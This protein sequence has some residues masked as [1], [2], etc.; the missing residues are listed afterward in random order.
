[1]K[2]PSTLSVLRRMIPGACAESFG[3]LDA[4]VKNAAA[5]EWLAVP[6]PGDEGV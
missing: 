3:F 6:R 5:T 4:I 1:M 2:V